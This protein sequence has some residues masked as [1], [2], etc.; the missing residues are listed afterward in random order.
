M[1]CASISWFF[2]HC[3]LSLTLSGYAL[4][5]IILTHAI[6]LYVLRNDNILLCRCI[7]L[8]T[9]NYSIKQQE[10]FEMNGISCNLE[11][12]EFV[13]NT[14]LFCWKWTA[15]HW[16]NNSKFH[17][18]KGYVLFCDSRKCVCVANSNFMLNTN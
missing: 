12:E 18:Q 4:L 1:N 2:C 17:D 3:L 13:E 16:I 8:S 14:Y 7:G 9:H 6:Y 10:G 11:S 15:R 5:T